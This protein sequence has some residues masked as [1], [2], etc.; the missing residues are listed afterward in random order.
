MR[1]ASRV[2][3]GGDRRRSGAETQNKRGQNLFHDFFSIVRAPQGSLYYVV[4]FKGENRAGDAINP[5]IRVD[6]FA[7]SKH[8][9]FD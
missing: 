5:N 6:V 1:F 3:G 4:A 2:R 8:R 9:C 7:L